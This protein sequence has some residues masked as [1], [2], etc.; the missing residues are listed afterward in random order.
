MPLVDAPSPLFFCRPRCESAAKSTGRS[1][2]TNEVRNDLGP[3]VPM[4]PQHDRTAVP[5]ITPQAPT[6]PPPSSGSPLIARRG[7]TSPRSQSQPPAGS[8]TSGLYPGWSGSSPRDSTR[9]RT[10][11]TGSVRLGVH[12]E[13]R[14]T[15]PRSLS[16]QRGDL[17][18]IGPTAC[19]RSHE[20]RRAWPAPGRSSRFRDEPQLERRARRRRR[21]CSRRPTELPAQAR[22]PRPEIRRPLHL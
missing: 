13:P 17:P 22:G 4:R 11:T 10:S 2:T 6:P 14:P 5:C 3:A 21:G 19:R 12:R 1:P 15:R 18:A 16:D 20:N 9:L 7:S 8:T